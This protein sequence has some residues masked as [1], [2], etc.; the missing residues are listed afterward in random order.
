MAD[1]ICVYSLEPET[2][3]GK[4]LS[5]SERKELRI[6]IRDNCEW[7]LDAMPRKETISTDS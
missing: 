6:F 7:F 2:D 3:K 5:L 4:I 1:G